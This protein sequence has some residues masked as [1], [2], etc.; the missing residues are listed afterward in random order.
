MSNEF[1]QYNTC[2][3]TLGG[4]Y[5]LLM[6]KNYNLYKECLVLLEVQK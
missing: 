1:W 3:P 2:V 4:G 5:I 6:W